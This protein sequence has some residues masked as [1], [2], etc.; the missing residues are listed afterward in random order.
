[1]EEKAI[2][3]IKEVLKNDKKTFEN[4]YKEIQK[5][6]ASF[7]NTRIWFCLMENFN[8]LTLK[9]ITFFCEKETHDNFIKTIEKEAYILLSNGPRTNTEILSA[10][11]CGLNERDLGIVL[12]NKFIQRVVKVGGKTKRLYF[13]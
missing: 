13:C 9:G 6:N 1:M 8:K 7:T 10:L 5:T 12:K 2:L 3:A 11:N 4:I